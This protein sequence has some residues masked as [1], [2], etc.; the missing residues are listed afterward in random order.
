[1]TDKKTLT[2]HQALVNVCAKVV[3]VKRDTTGQVGNQKYSYATI[4]AV[5]EV[6]Q[7]LLAANGL[8]L[9][10]YVDGDALKALLV[11]ESGE[12]LEMGAYNLGNFIDSQNAARPSLMGGVI[13]YAQSSASHKRM[14]MARRPAS[15]LNR[16]RLPMA[17]KLPKV[18]L[19]RLATLRSSTPIQSQL[20]T[21]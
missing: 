12:K 13:S 9:L 20:L 19:A 4:D 5:L 3:N 11:H 17:L 21:A 1:M 8:A 15:Q 2:I 14:M 10:Q 6:T 18:S 7:P 16:I